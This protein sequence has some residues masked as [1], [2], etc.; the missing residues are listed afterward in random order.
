MTYHTALQVINPLF[1][2]KISLYIYVVMVTEQEEWSP[3][4]A[5]GR[6][7]WVESV[8]VLQVEEEEDD[9]DHPREN[10][11]KVFHQSFG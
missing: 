4:L 2:I 5:S 7:D 1:F 11:D 8:P 6:G 3:T 9:A 10:E